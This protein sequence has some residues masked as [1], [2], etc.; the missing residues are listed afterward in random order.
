MNR[1]AF[2]V[3]VTRTKSA[4]T[5]VKDGR[6]LSLYDTM[7]PVSDWLMRLTVALRSSVESRMVRK[8][9]GRSSVPPV[10][11]KYLKYKM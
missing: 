6:P 9:R 8:A 1:D 10:T 11:S 4:E 2:A 7:T 5:S 3:V